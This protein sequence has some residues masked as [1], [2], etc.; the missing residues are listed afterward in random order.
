MGYEVLPHTAD[1][2]IRA[3]GRTREE[4]FRSALRGMSSVMHPEAL[5]Q[6]P[7]VEREIAVSASDTPSLLVD[8]L[9]EALSL[10]HTN[11]ELYTDVEFAELADT[12]LRAALRGVP[13]EGFEKDIK[14]ATYHGVEVKETDGGY[15]ATVIYDI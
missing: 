14:A 6:A 13:V 7:N 3:W 1:L 2:R 8:F 12:S 4:L 11:H 15:E 5:R 10:A 9:S